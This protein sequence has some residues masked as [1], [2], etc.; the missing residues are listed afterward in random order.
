MAGPGNIC[1][2][3]T[4]GRKSPPSVQTNRRG[5]FAG[6]DV[7]RPARA[8][9]VPDGAPFVR[10]VPGRRNKKQPCISARLYPRRALLAGNF[11]G[12]SPAL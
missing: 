8:V 2:P 3:R 5:V 4:A 12:D 6:R 10:N 1:A 9:L 7:R 11:P